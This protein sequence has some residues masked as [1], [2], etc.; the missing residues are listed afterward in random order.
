MLW[1]ENTALFLLDY[2]AVFFLCIWTVGICSS[3]AHR[4]NTLIPTANSTRNRENFSHKQKRH[5]RM[6][7]FSGTAIGLAVLLLPAQV[8]AA[9]EF[10]FIQGGDFEMGSPTLE[11]RRE[12]DEIRHHVTIS[13]FYLGS[14]EVTQSSYRELMGNNP[15][16]FQGEDLPVENVSWYDAVLYCNARSTAENLTPAYIVTG[17]G[18]DRTVTWNREA[19]G[20]RLPTEAE[21]EYA[22]RAGTTTPFSTGE[23][24]TAQQA[25]YY[26]TYPYDGFPSGQYRSR[27]MP[28]GSFAPNAWGLYD[29]H[30][31]VWEWCWDWY[32][33]YSGLSAVNP[34][35]A[36]SG[37]Y[38][39][40]RG[41]GWNDFGRHLRS[42]Y[43]AAY[44][45]ENKTFNVGFRLAR[46][47]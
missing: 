34:A 5:W 39:V 30:G 4:G 1:S 31:N 3:L 43:R 10:V 41:G 45:P 21:W 16:Q 35:G 2:C 11:N 24:V 18:D 38:R 23:N 47:G 13:S 25:N 26:G 36:D 17:S 29:M 9:E 42:A 19:N 40:N 8:Q 20:Y 14:K 15:S 37:T 32:G 22:C 46:N 44:P 33:S 6:N 28:V 7:F 12:K 27:T